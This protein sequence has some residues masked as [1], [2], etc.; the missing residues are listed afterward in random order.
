MVGIILSAGRGRRLLPITHYVPKVL[1]PLCGKRL[2]DYNLELLG[3]VCEEVLVIGGHLFEVLER[4]LKNRDVKLLRV[5]RVEEGNLYTLLRAMDLVRG[6]FI[7]TNG[8][9]LFGK[10]LFEHF[11]PFGRR[12]VFVACQR[13]REILEDEMKVLVS[14][15]RVLKMDKNLKSFDGAFVGL[16]YVNE[17]GFWEV[18]KRLG[19]GKV[20]DVLVEFNPEVVWIDDVPFFEIDDI[21]DWRRARD[22]CKGLG[23]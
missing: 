18:A 5:D 3:G 11:K 2:I 20:E 4:Y 8:D 13:E 1:I 14:S 19:S 6:D 9:H 23:L 16:T 22:G 12:G 15:G 7:V 21:K 17:E 10:N